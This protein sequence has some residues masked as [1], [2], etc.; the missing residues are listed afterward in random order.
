MRK[1]PGVLSSGL[2]AI[3][4]VVGAAVAVIAVGSGA[5]QVISAPVALAA[6][7]VCLAIRMVGLLSG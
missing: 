2:Y 5:S 7:G 3:P 1:A 6:A 4:A